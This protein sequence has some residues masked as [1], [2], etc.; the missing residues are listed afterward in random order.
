MA[1]HR[2][3][4]SDTIYDWQASINHG[5]LYASSKGPSHLAAR[6][7]I[8]AVQLPSSGKNRRRHRALGVV[9][10]LACEMVNVP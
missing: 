2:K 8:R 3:E 10:G 7:Y 5:S 6:T 4:R 1:I 9:M